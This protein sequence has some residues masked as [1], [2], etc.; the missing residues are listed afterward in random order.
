ML[1]LLETIAMLDRVGHPSLRRRLRVVRRE[2]LGAAAD[3]DR[4]GLIVLSDAGADGGV[5][6]SLSEAGRLLLTIGSG[7][8]AG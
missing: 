4:V 2:L 1:R 8:R 7:R 6:V 5:W 3:L